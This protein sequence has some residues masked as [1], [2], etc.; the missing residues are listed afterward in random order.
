MKTV[1]RQIDARGQAQHRPLLRLLDALRQVRCGE[2]VLLA[3]TDPE[4]ER[5]LRDFCRQ[6]G[7]RIVEE[8]HS[9]G[10]DIR[11]IRKQCHPWRRGQPTTSG[12]SHKRR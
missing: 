4:T 6:T 2:V 12:P 11:L 8:I 7:H 3:T 5:D 9:D 10:E 1:A